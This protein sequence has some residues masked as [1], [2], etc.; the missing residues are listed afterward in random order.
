MVLKLQSLCF[1]QRCYTTLQIGNTLFEQLGDCFIYTKYLLY[2][3]C[4][5][6]MFQFQKQPSK[7]VEKHTFSGRVLCIS[8]FTENDILYIHFLY[9]SFVY[10]KANDQRWL[11]TR[12]RRKVI[13]I[14]QEKGGCCK[15]FEKRWVT[16]LF[17]NVEGMTARSSI[18]RHKK[19]Q[20]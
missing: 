9:T 15:W 20:N 18:L 3:N 6:L 5:L 1:S 8:N 19:D 17:R 13:T 12:K 16:M 10:K 11:L 4:A 2:H 7:I 14:F